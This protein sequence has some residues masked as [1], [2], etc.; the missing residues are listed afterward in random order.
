MPN[1]PSTLGYFIP[2]FPGQTHIFFWR[3]LLAIRST[4]QSAQLISTR[5]ADLSQVKHL[6]ATPASKETFYL[7]PPSLASF[8]FPLFN[9]SWFIKS[10]KYIAALPD[11]GLAEKLKVSYFIIAAANMIRFCRNNNIKHVHG[12]SCASVAHILALASLHNEISYSLTLHGGLNTY[13]NNHKNKFSHAKFVSTVTRP[14]QKEVNEKTG[15]PL[16]RIPVISMGVDLSKFNYIENKQNTSHPLK[17]VTVA[18]LAIG[19][20]HAF[21]L[22]ALARL[23]EQGFDFHYTIVGGGEARSAIEEAINRH[24]LNDQVSLTGSLGEE[25]VL[26]ILRDSDVLMLTSFGEFEAA[27]VCVM[28][29]MAIG[30]PTIT[31]IIGGTRDM[32]N[33]S[34]DG[35]LVEQRNV[36]QIEQAL[37]RFLTNRQL[38][39]QFG[40]AARQKAEKDFD[41]VLQAKKLIAEINK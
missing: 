7:H 37:L 5:K 29:A 17:L 27:P 22:Q 1:L 9:I 25:D 39:T 3:E 15:L 26:A 11:G 36:D 28:E 6:F 40:E 10:L 18:R 31:S 33:D 19:K 14:L 34:V 23:K 41:A 35:F 4:G 13:G 16:N 8:F 20:G 32:I 12:H 38:V 30:I 2:E 21:T 24:Q